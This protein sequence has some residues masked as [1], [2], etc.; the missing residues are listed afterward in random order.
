MR[1][2]LT[3]RWGSSPPSRC[4][5]TL[6]ALTAAL[7]QWVRQLLAPSCFRALCMSPVGQKVCALER[8]FMIFKV[9][10]RK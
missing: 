9:F 7:G 6:A 5:T 3:K 1:R 4:S 2:T 8:G 10:F